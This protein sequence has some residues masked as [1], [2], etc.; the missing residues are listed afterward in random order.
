[1]ANSAPVSTYDNTQPLPAPAWGWVDIPSSEQSFDASTPLTL[2][3]LALA[4]LALAPL[5][6]TQLAS[7][8][9][10]STELDSTELNSTELTP[11][12]SFPLAL[13]ALALVPL[14]SP[15]LTS[16]MVDMPSTL[17]PPDHP[18]ILSELDMI[19]TF[20]SPD[21]RLPVIDTSQSSYP[22]AN[23]AQLP[24]LSSPIMGADT[25]IESDSWQGVDS[26]LSFTDA[27]DSTFFIPADDF[28]PPVIDAHNDFMLS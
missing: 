28:F 26:F 4:P 2:T 5:T 17:H 15:S 19:L 23:A 3:P 16:G 21:S 25:P 12:A 22:H 20:L 9:L 14:T 24:S 8:Q 27:I 18:H 11:L 10:E 6:L 13:P 7:M 1:M